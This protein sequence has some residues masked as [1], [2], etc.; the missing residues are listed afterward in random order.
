MRFWISLC[1]G[2]ALSA[3]VHAQWSLPEDTMLTRWGKKVS[4][5][6]AWREYPRPQFRREDQWQN[7]NGLWKYAVN[8]QS[9]AP[10]QYDGDILV[11]YPI[12]SALSGVQRMLEPE[13]T[14]WYRRTFQH[15]TPDGHRTHLLFE[16]V[17]YECTVVINGKEV[18][19]HVGSSDPFKFDIT[20]VLR[21]GENELVVRVIDRT[22]PSQT[23][24]KQTL[25]P[26]GIY[27]TRVSGIWQTVWLEDVPER[28]FRMV[29]MKPRIAEGTLRVLPTLSG[30]PLE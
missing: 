25:E 13:E 30:Q 4:P 8:R 10:Q 27:Y 29:K 9:H 17:D 16:A 18:G 7:L 28:H 3:T 21:D 2:I 11:P 15:Q 14:L 26:K 6:N 19:S 12:E 23:L 5:E 24:G 1:V 22:A 20:D